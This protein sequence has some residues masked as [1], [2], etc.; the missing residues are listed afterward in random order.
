MVDG[1]PE[2]SE[3]FTLGDA[4]ELLDDVE[5][6]LAFDEHEQSALAVEAGDD[7]S[8]PRVRTRRGRR[9][10]GAF[11]DGE[12]FGYLE[13]AVGTGGFLAVGGGLAGQLGGEDVEASMVNVGVD[14][15]LAR[16][17]GDTL[18]AQVGED[19]AGGAVAVGDFDVQELGNGGV[20]RHGAVFV[21]VGCF[22]GGLAISVIVPDFPVLGEI[23]L[24]N[25]AT[26]ELVM[27]GAGRHSELAGERPEEE[28]DLHGLAKM[29]VVHGFDAGSHF[30]GDVLSK[31]A[32]DVVK[33]GR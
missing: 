13:V 2:E 30:T 32:V 1:A 27:E 33:S 7:V 24:R 14:R 16:Q 23:G 4:A 5:E 26:A 9:G 11:F 6:C 15:T 10:V 17:L 22:D 18:F 29:A 3:D 12:I 20:H 19:V 25:D 8:I 21:E 31:R 28:P